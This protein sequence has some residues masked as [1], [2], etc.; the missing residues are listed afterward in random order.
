MI[1]ETHSLFP[2]LVLRAR[3][4]LSENECKTV[5]DFLLKKENMEKLE[6]HSAIY[7]EKSLSTYT[8]LQFNVLDHIQKEVESCSNIVD[9]VKKIIEEYTLHSGFK[10]EGLSN[11]WFNIQNKGSLL[12]QH[13][14]PSCSISGAIY[15]N[16]DKNSSPIFFENPNT[17]LV[18]ST[19]KQMISTKY[20][21]DAYAFQPKLGDLFLFPSW[22]KHGSNNNINY[23]D[24]RVVISFNVF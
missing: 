7:G 1:I 23:T 4:F 2:T 14:H 16:V 17:L 11:S 15:I 3:E 9:N 20:S 5:F 13:T 18:N 22:L 8:N 19:N 12:K 24:N 21:F 10:T 6:N